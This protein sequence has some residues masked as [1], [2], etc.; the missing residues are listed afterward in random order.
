MRRLYAIQLE[1][2]QRLV[3]TIADLWSQGDAVAIVDPDAPAERTAERL[4]A[5]RPHF[6]VS[7]GRVT[8]WDPAAPLMD[9]SDRV[10]VTTSGTTGPPK[11]VV[12]TE[13]GL[14]ASAKAVHARLQATPSDGWLC[15]LSPLYIG[16]LAIIARSLLDGLPVVVTG[17]FDQKSLD[18]A[19]EQGA[20]LAAAVTPVLARADLSG[21]RAVILGAQPAPG[22]LPA[23]AISTYGMTETG[24]GVV[25]G[26]TPLETVE[27]SLRA[28]EIYLRGPMI[29]RSTRSGAALLDA[30]G[31]LA[32]GD[33]GELDEA[34]RLRV[35]GRG[36]DL[37]NTG[38]SKVSPD[39]VEAAI[40][41][42]GAPLDDFAVFGAADPV[43][44]EV[45][46]LAFSGPARTSLADIQAAI[47]DLVEP[48]ELPRAM[49]QL[50]SIPRTETGKPRR[51]L[52]P[53]R[54]G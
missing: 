12:H 25:Y 17:G 32:T 21:F 39:R 13:E 26:G 24:S 1:R 2:T 11:A 54:R 42:A 23:N 22:R 49:L 9:R 53:E 16:G 50:P 40:R 52:L 10:V 45:V 48:Y 27:L 51:A 37:I 43:W 36:A 41:E 29:S 7:G 30:D 20:T 47:R 8:E 28:G 15:A 46:T 14:S 38:G 33:A 35:L 5:L 44:G 18:R 34:D 6:F 31:W 4:A 19:R 3:G